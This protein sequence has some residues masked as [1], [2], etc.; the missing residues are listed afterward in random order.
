MFTKL[1]WTVF[2]TQ[3]FELICYI[4]R[5]SCPFTPWIF[6][7]TQCGSPSVLVLIIYLGRWKPDGNCSREKRATPGCRKT[8]YFWRVLLS[9]CKL[10]K[11]LAGVHTEHCS[12]LPALGQLGT[13]CGS[14]PDM[15]TRK[16]H[17]TQ[18]F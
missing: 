17:V 8:N 6:I 12:A 1:F 16:E 5:Q 10:E 14:L 11:V 3:A 9:P 7:I 13:L 18:M 4:V 15:H 2:S